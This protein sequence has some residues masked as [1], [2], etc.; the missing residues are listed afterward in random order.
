MAKDF[1]FK[2]EWDDWLGDDELMACTLET[3][4][5]WIKCVA[6]MRRK[7]VAEFTGTVDQLR[8]KFGILPEELTR[9]LHDLK[10]NNAAD[11]RF[12]KDDVSIKSRRIERELKDKENNRLYVSR[13]RDKVAGKDE[14][15]DDVSLQSKSKSKS[16]SK[17]EE[18]T[19]SAST[20]RAAYELVTDHSRLMK[21]HADRIGQITDGGSQGQAIK[22][23]LEKFSEPDAL[24][25]YDFQVKELAVN[26]GWRSSPVSWRTVLTFIAEWVAMGRPNAPPERNGNHKNGHIA[27]GQV[28]K[29]INTEPE[30][31]ISCR[32]CCDSKR[33]FHYPTPGSV[34][35][36][37]EIECPDCVAEA[38]E[39]A[40][41][42]Q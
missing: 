3:Q 26:G 16:K 39:I 38:V 34:I 28:G 2:F 9:C 23:I 22:S 24:A 42:N 15:K 32:T 17:K 6:M 36:M 41:A 12:G 8:R 10:T 1:W 33:I 14:C 31:V 21:H 29:H 20:T 13:H 40:K 25:C 30:P 5:F 35:G 19:R 27:A 37:T 4:G 7:E 11:V 18:E